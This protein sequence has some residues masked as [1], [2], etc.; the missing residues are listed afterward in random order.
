M[1]R[2][3]LL[4][5]L[6]GASNSAIAEEF[7]YDFVQL[8][9]GTVDFA[10]TSIDCDGF[11]VNG[12]FGITDSLHIVGSYQSSDYF[13][14]ITDAT[15]WRVG[16]AGHKSLSERLDVV[17]RIEYVNVDVDPLIGQFQPGAVDDFR[18]EGFGLTIG[19]R[20][21]MMNRFEINANTFY[22]NLSDRG[23]ETGFGVGA[24]F[25]WT[26]SFSLGVFSSWADDVLSYQASARLYFN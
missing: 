23:D 4:A 5:S 13:E 7:N 8:S 19:V 10:M 9:Y 24:L 26:D 11:G 22:V 14:Y 18:D 3:L 1:K 21:A 6:L 15:E 25:N 12:S 20:A 2:Y 17:A 16:L